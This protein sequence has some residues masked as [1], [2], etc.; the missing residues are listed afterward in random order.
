MGDKK[1]EKTEGYLGVQ[2]LKGI[3]YGVIRKVACFFLLQLSRPLSGHA[4]HLSP[5]VIW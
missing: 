5:A 3:P 1:M 2:L 4:T